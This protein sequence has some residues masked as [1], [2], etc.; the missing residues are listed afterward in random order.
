MTHGSPL[1]AIFIAIDPNKAS[2]VILLWEFCALLFWQC[3]VPLMSVYFYPW[4]CSK[5]L[6]HTLQSSYRPST[7]YPVSLR[8]ILFACLHSLRN[9]IPV[10]CFLPLFSSNSS[11][12]VWRE[13]QPCQPE[14]TVFHSVPFSIG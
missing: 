4:V 13:F 2:D 3:I 9:W 7:S 8:I 1:T 12:Y 10:W 5:L 14:R 11:S 6:L